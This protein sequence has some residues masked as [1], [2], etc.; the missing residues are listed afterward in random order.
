M[1]RWFLLPLLAVTSWSTPA[2]AQRDQLVVSS[3]WLQ[4]HIKDDN[5]VLL[6]VGERAEYN[7]E[8]LP[9]AQFIEMSDISVSDRPN[10][11]VLELPDLP[12]LK[13]GLEKFGISDKSRIIVYYGNDWIS[14]STRVLYTLQYAGLGD[15]SSLLD[16]GMQSWKQE[17]KPVTTEVP[18]P[19]KGNVTIK[20]NPWIVVDADYV[21]SQIG[22]PGFHLIDARTAVFY[23]GTRDG[24]GR[25][26]HIAGA[27]SLPFTEIVDDKGVVAPPDSLTKLFASAGVSK[28]DTL[29]VYC[30]IGQQA[31]AVLF[32]AR[33]LGISVR[34][35][36]GSF[37]DWAKRA[38]FP[39]TGSVTKE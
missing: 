37:T 15:R 12:T 30:H 4:L 8:H 18:G 31:T 22:K 38:D 20:A 7:R 16:G 29:V 26:G 21:R 35:Y 25:S 2:A 13:A 3:E 14:P 39:V 6:H 33:T 11:K 17:G 19:K 32:G 9:G 10:N 34:L 36:D 23:D 5:L 28:G 1:R 27:T 24:G